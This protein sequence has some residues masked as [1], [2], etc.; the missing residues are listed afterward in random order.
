MKKN[1]NILEIIN[2]EVGYL[3]KKK[4][5]ILVNIDNVKALNG[6][7]ISLIGV[8]GAG[9]SSIL[10]SIIGVNKF[11]KGNVLIKNKFPKEYSKK[12]LA[13]IISIVSTESITLPNM[14]VE[15]LIII[16]RYPHKKA[17]EQTNKK[18]IE[19]VN[20]VLKL[21][22]LKGFAQLKINE[23]S[24]G[25]RQR[26]MIARA[27]AQDTD[28]I[29]LDE[30]ASFLDIENKYLTYG[31]L[32]KLATEKGK[33][34]IF[35]THD[36]SIAIKFSDKLWLIN[37]KLIIEGTPEDIIYNK[38]FDN[39]FDKQNLVFDNSVLDFKLK[40]TFTRKVNIINKTNK[41]NLFPLTL[42]A[43]N[44]NGFEYS[45]TEKEF[46]IEL[47]EIKEEFIIKVIYKSIIY[48]YNNFNKLISGL[49]RLF[50]TQT[51]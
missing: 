51:T 32:R 40:Q 1:T 3:S 19:I 39:I 27:L 4:K 49:N 5:N 20:N 45:N 25:E 15:N 9:K 14:T 30:P 21:V 24:D 12:N 36:L 31:I 13:K 43:L 16:G 22:G 33:T 50:T 26:V 8:N 46:I 37:N 23:I 11:L 48:E 2:A 41:R 38:V 44:R 29:L 34:I 47:E 7:V 17:F 6:E 18:D 35:S 28:I 10:K 42:N